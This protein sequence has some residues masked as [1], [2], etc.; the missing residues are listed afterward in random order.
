M[1]DANSDV[2]RIVDRLKKEELVVRKNCHAD[3]RKVN[4]TLTQKGM[5][6]L[7]SMTGLQQKMDSIVGNLTD[8]ELQELCRLLDKVRSQGES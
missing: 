5:D 8:D 3:R 1:L 2:T 4:I 7:E 6:L